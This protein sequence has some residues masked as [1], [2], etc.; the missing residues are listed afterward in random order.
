MVGG[1]LA[2]VPELSRG[3]NIVW[4]DR[5]QGVEL[6]VRHLSEQLR[7]KDAEVA[8]LRSQ[9]G[10]LTSDFKYNLKLLKE[11]DWELDQ[12]EHQMV[13]IDNFRSK[14]KRRN[15]SPVKHVCPNTTTCMLII[16]PI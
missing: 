15:R 7:T 12:N 16:R 3:W 1:I 13:R 2:T 5:S 6:R 14:Q 8:A 11:R 4:E 10:L 9:I